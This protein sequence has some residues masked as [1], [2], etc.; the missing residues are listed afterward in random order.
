MKG[1]I[2]YILR[3]VSHLDNTNIISGCIQ[4]AGQEISK[5]LYIL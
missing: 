5:Y 4:N 1:N 3:V 2:S